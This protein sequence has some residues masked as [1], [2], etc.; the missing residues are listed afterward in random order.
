LL[1]SSFEDGKHPKA[2]APGLY[3]EN[4]WLIPVTWA[5][6]QTFWGRPFVLM[7]G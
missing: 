5:A 6:K 3:P 1:W 7:S 2:I 4:I